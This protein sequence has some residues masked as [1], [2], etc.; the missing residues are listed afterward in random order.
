MSRCWV[1]GYA[2]SLLQIVRLFYK[3]EH[4][5]SN[6]ATVPQI[7]A[8]GLLAPAH[9]SKL[10]QIQPS[11]PLATFLAAELPRRIRSW[12]CVP[13]ELDLGSLVRLALRRAPGACPMYF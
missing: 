13:S 5:A 11:G 4:L 1:L 12:I 8:S 3:S 7:R 9:G 10:V 6:R 2:I